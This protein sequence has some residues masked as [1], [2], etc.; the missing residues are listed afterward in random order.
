M[1]DKKPR[2][3]ICYNLEKFAA[4]LHVH[5]FA[6]SF[7]QNSTVPS[8]MPYESVCTHTTVLL[9]TIHADEHS[10]SDTLK[11]HMYLPVTNSNVVFMH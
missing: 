6:C 1:P 4:L 5:A 7:T 2:M 3:L 8:A 9:V 10:E 11:A